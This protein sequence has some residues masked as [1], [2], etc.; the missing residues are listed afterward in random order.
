V[1]AL[2]DWDTH[3]INLTRSKAKA[4]FKA[5]H[6]SLYWKRYKI[7]KSIEKEDGSNEQKLESFKTR[8]QTILRNNRLN[9]NKL[10]EA[11]GE[12]PEANRSRKRKN[13]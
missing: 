8:H 11:I 12:L 6:R 9:Q 13:K 4:S 3:D 7:C 1:K 10:L 2:K 5:N